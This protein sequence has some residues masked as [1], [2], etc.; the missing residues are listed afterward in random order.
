L[1]FIN[2]WI[3]DNEGGL[4]DYIASL[5]GTGDHGF[6]QESVDASVKYRIFRTEN[7]YW[8]SVSS[9][10]KSSTSDIFDADGTSL[11]ALSMEDQRDFKIFYQEL[12]YNFSRKSRTNGSFGV[13][14]QWSGN[15]DSNQT[16]SN[17]KLIMDIIDHPD[18]FLM[19]P[20]NRFP[21]NPLPLDHE[22]LR[23]ITLTGD[24]QENYYMERKAMYLQAFL[25]F[26]HQLTRKVFFTGG[27]RAAYDILKLQHEA[28]FIDGSS[29]S[30][31]N[32][33][34]SYPNLIF[35]PSEKQD[36]NN[37]NLIITGQAGLT[38]RWN[39]KF[40]FF[41]NASHA[42]K[43]DLLQ[44]RW[45]SRQ[46][47]L[48]GEKIN[49]LE[50]GWKFSLAGRIFWNAT[51]FYR[52]H[53]NLQTVIWRGSAGDG[54]L[55]GTGRA[56]SYGAETGIKT[57]LIKGLEVFADYSWMFSQFDSTDVNSRNFVYAGNRFAYAPEHSYSAGIN[58]KADIS[59][60]V[61]IFITPWYSG[62]SGYWFT[63]NNTSG[64]SQNSYGLLNLNAGLKLLNPKMTLS[65]YGK[66]I[67]EQKYFAGA[68]YMGGLFGI[69]AV[70][71][72]MP[73]MFGGKLKWEF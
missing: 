49:S 45:D 28:A 9:F 51:G 50:A 70:R 52:M 24:R 13:S 8:T 66:N 59:K 19:P 22:P 5:D 10:R 64:L 17:D 32:Y 62:K 69:P 18:N 40:N 31:G 14:Y 15:R 73:R 26:T 37:K 36:V 44:I 57:A 30:L 34:G 72:G 53:E 38:Y 42:K 3:S 21:V 16:A 68:G 33:T 71:P 2:P 61:R 46:Q 7:K 11:P 63:E 58:A 1:A 23:N 67:L 29:S 6:Q 43:P 4:F 47:V 12:R 27:V 41:I 20:D 54:L 56:L 65:I 55:D 25:H 60:S 48:A 35:K 39:E